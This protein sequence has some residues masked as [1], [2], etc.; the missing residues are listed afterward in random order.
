KDGSQVFVVGW[1][2][3]YNDTL[4]ILDTT[5]QQVTEPFVAPAG[6]SIYEAYPSAGS[7]SVAVAAYSISEE[8]GKETYS[9]FLWKPFEDVIEPLDVSGNTVSLSDDGNLLVVGSER[10]VIAWDVARKEAL[11]S[12]PFHNVAT[13]TL[14]ADDTKVA[15]GTW[16]GVVEVLDVAD[17]AVLETPVRLSPDT[18]AWRLEFDPR[19]DERLLVVDTAA[20]TLWDIRTISGETTA[21]AVSAEGQVGTSDYSGDIRIWSETGEELQ[22]WNAH[23]GQAWDLAFFDDEPW[24]V[25]GG[26]DGMAVIWDVST[27]QPRTTVN[28]NE[29]GVGVNA[30]AASPDGRTFATGGWDGFV[31]TW[32][33]TGEPGC[34]FDESSTV[35]AEVAFDE[36]SRRLIA[37]RWDGV[38]V[39]DLADCTVDPDST[40]ATHPDGDLKHAAFDLAGRLMAT[41]DDSGQRVE[42]YQLDAD[43]SPREFPVADIGQVNE[44]ALSEDG[45]TLAAA[46]L[47]R[48][49]VVFETATGDRLQAF[50]SLGSV[51]HVR[52]A[53]S[54]RLVSMSSNRAVPFLVPLSDTG[55]QEL[56]GQLS[57]RQLTSD[58][59]AR[60]LPEELCEGWVGAASSTSPGDGDRDTSLRVSEYRPS[61]ETD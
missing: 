40:K 5:G 60:L 48:G 59:C 13:V 23:T 58:E 4:H 47:D 30:V 18:W 34:T 37:A 44:V 57:S 26:N 17:G 32:S 38:T 46:T 29:D 9:I 45:Q 35:V 22:A 11:W 12:I 56:A 20:A 25:T 53:G 49:L 8:S 27:A 54:D 3:D 41:V 36:S 10:E 16:D 19:D 51:V 31:H 7:G 50:E 24:V 43:S 14:N 6:Y 21:V 33:V 61:G 1:D 2:S 52:A 28:V 42:V 15:V 39:Y 55:L